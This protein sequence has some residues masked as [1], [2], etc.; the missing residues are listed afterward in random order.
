MQIRLQLETLLEEKGRL[1]HENSIYSREN[2]FLREIVEYHQLTMQDV[3]YVNEG[4]EEVEEVCPIQLPPHLSS[5]PSPGRLSAMAGSPSSSNHS[6]PRSNSNHTSP[7]TPRRH[8]DTPE[9]FLT[10]G[11]ASPSS[12]S[13]PKVVKAETESGSSSSSPKSDSSRWQSSPTAA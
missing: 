7:R 5:H 10:A 11:S 8:N 12:P 3:V 9:L 1:A 6:S 4:I 2:R 13:S